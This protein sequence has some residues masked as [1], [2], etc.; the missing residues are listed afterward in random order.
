MASAGVQKNDCVQF[1]NSF[2]CICL[3]VLGLFFVFNGGKQQGSKMLGL[4]S[5]VMSFSA[6]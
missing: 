5:E 4:F 2:L 6:L 3:F 1:K